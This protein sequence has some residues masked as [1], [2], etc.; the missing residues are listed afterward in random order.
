MTDKVQNKEVVKIMGSS[1]KVYVL[2]GVLPLGYKPQW[3]AISHNTIMKS[4]GE[5]IQI[6]PIIGKSMQFSPMSYL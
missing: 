5:L 1:S 6:S 2:M 4:K 3:K